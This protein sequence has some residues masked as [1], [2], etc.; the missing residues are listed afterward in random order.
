MGDDRR[1]GGRFPGR[2]R[3]SRALAVIPTRVTVVPGPAL[4]DGPV[5]GG[6]VLFVV[7][8][9]RS[10]L[11][12]VRPDQPGRLDVPSLMADVER[13]S[14]L[15]AVEVLAR[16]FALLWSATSVS[17]L[18]ADY[19]GDHLARLVLVMAEGQRPAPTPT[20]RSTETNRSPLRITAWSPAAGPSALRSR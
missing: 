18:I 15:D 3:P 1:T 7:P 10:I 12:R 16:Q 8:P 19:S 13:A 14:P 11:V 5:T 2:A 9:D 20:P 4:R 17:F 6:R